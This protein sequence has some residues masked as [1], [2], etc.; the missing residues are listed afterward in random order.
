MTAFRAFH[1]R[2][3]LRHI[4]TA[5]LTHGHIVGLAASETV[6]LQAVVW[7]AGALGE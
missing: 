7:I 6:I 5:F 4:T 3:T 2:S 1:T